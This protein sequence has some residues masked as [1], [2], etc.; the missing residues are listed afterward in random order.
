M[1][2][3]LMAAAVMTSAAPHQPDAAAVTPPERSVAAVR[4]A[5]ASLSTPAMGATASLQAP[6]VTTAAAA[7][8]Q[9]TVTTD[10]VIA[11]AGDNA[12]GA[13][14]SGASCREMD[15]SDLLLDMQ[16]NDRLDAVIPLGDVQYECGE[17]ANF[18]LADNSDPPRGYDRSWGRVKDITTP[19][20][21][22]HEYRSDPTACLP[23]GTGAPGYYTYFGQA[24]SPL[25]DNCTAA[26]KGYYSYDLGSWHIVV[27]NS[28]CGQVPNGGCGV[29]GAQATWLRAD[30]AAS[31]QQCIAAAFHHPRYSSSTRATTNTQYLWEILY[32]AGADVV[33]TGHEHSYERFAKLGRSPSASDSLEPVL[34]PAG[35]RQFVVGTGGRNLSSF[36][37]TVRTGSQVRESGT[38]GVL[39]MVLHPDSYDW[40]FVP[41]AGETFTDVGSTACNGTD[42]DT[43][44]PSVP[45][46]VTAS[47]TPGRVDLSWSA[48]SDD[49]G[50]T[51][52]EVWRDGA[53]LTT[54]DAPATSA[55]DLAVTAGA[56]YG[57][58]VRALDAA[59]NSSD[60]SSPPVSVVVPE[61]LPPGT[62]APTADATV[63]EGAPYNNYATTVLSADSGPGINVEGYIR[64][65]VSGLSDPVQQATLRLFVP[66]GSSDGPAM[67][68]TTGDW[69]ETGLTWNN[70]PPR[71]TTSFADKDAVQGGTFVDY[72]VTSQVTGNGTYNW[73]FATT[74]TD[75]TDFNS[76]EMVDPPRLVVT[77][78][79][80]DTEA[81][82][83]PTGLT[84]TAA[85]TSSVDL[86]WTASTDDTA[87][88]GYDVWR[89][90]SLVTTVADTTWTDTGLAPESSHTYRVAAR[91]AAGNTSAPSDPATAT[92]QAGPR[93]FR[94][95]AD[96]RVKESSPTSNYGDTYL[97]AD[98]GTGVAVESYLRFDVAGLSDPVQQ[99]T[100]RLY[101]TNSSKD[102]PGVYPTSNSW[103]ESTI[104][105][106]NRP[107]RDTTPVADLGTVRKGTWVEYDVTSL[108]AGNGT[109][110]IALATP[111]TD[112]SDFDSRE[113]GN[114]PQLVVTTATP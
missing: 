80:P 108:V 88:T 104:T 13:E 84:A 28:N 85:G 110:S 114:P 105:W 78:G 33:L 107:T 87:V 55:A 109:Y 27:L 23:Q 101:V 74:S 67:Y 40:N 46:D 113:M 34:D 53:L 63:K 102:G 45:G 60:L 97:R 1:L 29:N 58:Q 50:V 18:N 30:L 91:D 93:V 43:R 39:R 12:C 49:V 77:T 54:V 52:Y 72:D 42:G 62:F 96:A 8:L 32:D 69:S 92:T 66:N 31:G 4:T 16:A 25:D 68:T 79:A 83:T 90:G 47:A 7:A 82:S 6:D 3:W 94:P 76:R 64:F 95:V 98:N 59:G 100:L 70:R 44:P 75:G 111:S 9:T 56:T 48:S 106:N 19:V 15:T 22:N 86:A 17:L 14:S 71:S 73:V 51:A 24:A 21:G 112:A 5:T 103:D 89:D 36:A 57:Y 26:C 41:V 61:P 20:V 99:A 10:P 2:V 11:V 35:M 65:A 38:F 37:G 81:P